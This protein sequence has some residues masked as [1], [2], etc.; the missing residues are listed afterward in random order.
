M[1]RALVE[2]A[3]ITE[4]QIAIKMATGQSFSLSYSRARR[5]KNHNAWED[6]Q[7][8]IYQYIEKIQDE[9]SST[10]EFEDTFSKTLELLDQKR[11]E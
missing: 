3:T 6:D 4:R 1:L 11:D 9:F 7:D 8:Y 5:N 10:K 2:K